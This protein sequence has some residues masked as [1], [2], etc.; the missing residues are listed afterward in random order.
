MLVSCQQLE[1]PDIPWHVGHP[2]VCTASW[3]SLALLADEIRAEEDGFS[4]FAEWC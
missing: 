1:H 2:A 3:S 4:R